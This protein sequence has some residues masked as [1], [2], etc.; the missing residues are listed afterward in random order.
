MMIREEQIMAVLLTA[1]A[2]F[3]GGFVVAWVFVWTAAT[4]AM[5]RQSDRNLQQVGE[6]N[7]QLRTMREAREAEQ[8]LRDREYETAS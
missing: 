5:S 3:V 8:E 6:L 4:R 7:A 1:L 2:C